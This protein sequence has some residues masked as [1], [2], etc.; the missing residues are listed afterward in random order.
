MARCW[1][2]GSQIHGVRYLFTCPTCEGVS[3]MKDIRR[4]VQGRGAV[5]NRGV[6]MLAAGLSEIAGK[7]S[8]VSDE[9]SVLASVVEWGFEEIKW[10]LQQQTQILMSI[11]KTLKTPSQTQAKEW[12]TMAEELRQRACLDEAEDWF[13]KALRLN[14]LDYRIYI[15]LA[16]TCLRK[17]DFDKAKDLLEKSLPHAPRC[18]RVVVAKGSDLEQ[19]LRDAGR[20]TSFDLPLGAESGGLNA[21][22]QRHL[23]L[24]KAENHESLEIWFQLEVTEEHDLRVSGFDYRS[25]S[26]RLLGRIYACQEDYTSAASAL[27]SAIQFSPDYPEGNYEYAQYCVISNSGQKEWPQCLHRAILA[28]PDY[29]YMAKA[30]RNFTPARRQVENLLSDMQEQARQSVVSGIGEAEQRLRE[31]T[32]AIPRGRAHPEERYW[33][34]RWEPS[35]RDDKYEREVKKSPPAGSF[36]DLETSLRSVV[37]NLTTA[38]TAAAS[39][40]YRTLLNATHRALQ[41]T[42]ISKQVEEGVLSKSRELDV[43]RSERLR[44][45]RSCILENMVPIVVYGVP[46]IA[47]LGLF[48][49]WVLFGKAGVGF[50]LGLLLGILWAIRT[51][52]RKLYE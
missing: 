34:R 20:P 48:L 14:P 46:G 3:V 26:Y 18:K 7:V 28:K 44:I 37:E 19:A 5:E 10:E 49:G 32:A 30:E 25:Q 1:S 15:G 33:R 23:R 42:R 35:W 38:K 52:W 12:R 21:A 24:E 16:M 29:W 13:L 40:D 47:V 9:L 2:C 50:L 4:G 36:D 45:N 43:K 39:R 8:R 11:D 31:A 27:Q 17:N 22:L 41:A 51:F 6:E